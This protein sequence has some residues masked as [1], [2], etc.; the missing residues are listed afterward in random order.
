MLGKHIV[1]ALRDI[2]TQT[3]KLDSNYELDL[4]SV[5]WPKPS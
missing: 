5:T 2:T 3:P 4:T 1:M